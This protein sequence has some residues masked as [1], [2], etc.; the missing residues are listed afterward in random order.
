[1]RR[2][3]VKKGLRKLL[4]SWAVLCLHCTRANGLPLRLRNP[5]QLEM[6][7]Q[8]LCAKK[9]DKILSNYMEFPS[10]L[11]SSICWPHLCSE[12]ATLCR[13]LKQQVSCWAFLALSTSP[14][15]IL[16]IV[17]TVMPSELLPVR[18]T[19]REMMGGC[20]V[21][22]WHCTN[23][24]SPPSFGLIHDE[25]SP[26]CF[27]A[28]CITVMNVQMLWICVHQVCDKCVSLYQCYTPSEVGMNSPNKPWFILHLS[29]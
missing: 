23:L 9:W 26:C 2:G 7:G 17:I 13:R 14:T 20:N 8:P 24:I 18:N 22:C 12:R 16:P 6:D 19:G 27:C 1:M 11:S 21:I 10:T 4:D 5:T 15:Q 28:S 25:R 29:L 3:N